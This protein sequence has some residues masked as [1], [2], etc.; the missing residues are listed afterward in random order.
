[1]MA[2]ILRMIDIIFKKCENGMPDRKDIC[3]VT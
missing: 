3:V 2:T 1:M